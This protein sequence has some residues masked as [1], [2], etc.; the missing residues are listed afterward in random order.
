MT[1]YVV[2]RVIQAAVVLWLVWTLVFVLYFVVPEQPARVLLGPRAPESLVQHLTQALGL[3]RPLWV[4]YAGYFGRILHGD[5]GRSFERSLMTQGAP[6][7]SVI[8]ADIPVDLALGIPAAAL[9]LLIG[10]GI[11]ILAVRR[12]GTLRARGAMAVALTFVSM[13]AFVL[14]G[15]LLYVSYDLLAPHGIQLYAVHQWVPLH[16]NPLSW[17]HHLVLPWFTLALVNSAVYARL[18]RGSLRQVLQEDY[19]RTARSKGISERRVLLRHALRAAATP[20]M[21]QFGLDLAAV[22]TGVIVVEV[23]FDIPG[24]GL[25]LVNAVQSEDLPTIQ[26]IVIFLS[27]VVVTAN[28]VVDLLYGVLDP[29]VRLAAARD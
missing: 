20:L 7:S 25:Q 13:P 14:G 5:L 17:A 6:V 23:V 4:Q 8:A 26:G 15:V 29:R 2:R 3:D 18:S 19:I 16:V 28:L 21:T 11:G 1:G 27:A 9:W 10:L 22:L 12:P 24:L